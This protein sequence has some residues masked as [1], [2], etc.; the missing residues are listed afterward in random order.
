MI[1]LKKTKDMEEKMMTAEEIR[2]RIERIEAQVESA[3]KKIDSCRKRMEFCAEDLKRQ[4]ALLDQKKEIATANAQQAVLD[5]AERIRR[6]EQAM[7]DNINAIEFYRETL[8]SI[9]Q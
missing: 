4:L 5:L 8:K 7:M 3:K 1:L 6:S 2:L 9:E